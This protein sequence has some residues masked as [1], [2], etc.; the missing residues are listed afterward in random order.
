MVSETS[1]KDIKISQT[2]HIKIGKFWIQLRHKKWQME[3]G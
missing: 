2:S 3:V 1:V